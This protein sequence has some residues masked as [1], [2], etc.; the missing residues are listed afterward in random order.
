MK[1]IFKDIKG[2]EGLYQIS[3]LGRIKSLARRKKARRNKAGIHYT[4]PVT[5]KIMRLRPDKNFGYYYTNLSKNGKMKTHK[6][7]RLVAEHFIPNPQN[8]YAVNHKDGNKANNTITNLEW[9]TQS[10][11]EI[12]ANLNKLKIHK[13]ERAGGVKLN[14]DKVAKIRNEANSKTYEQLSM[15]YKVS[16]SQIFRIINN[17]RWTINANSK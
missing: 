15:E 9:V 1:E 5:E 12:H 2:Y 17:E 14:W 8:K 13:P 3:N 7:H 4:L 16:P 6:A 11:N 10:E